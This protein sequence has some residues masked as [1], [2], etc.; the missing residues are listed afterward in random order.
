MLNKKGFTMVEMATTIVIAIPLVFSM[1]YV[2]INLYSKYK[3]YNN[4]TNYH[5][6]VNTLKNSLVHDLRVA[7]A[8]E[9]NK[10]EFNVGNH[11]YKFSDK[12]VVR[13]N[14]EISSYP[15]EFQMEDEVIR[16]KDK[17]TEL[18][19]PVGA[20]SLREVKLNE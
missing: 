3:D 5:M 6:E 17:N 18:E 11:S 1:I 9:K 20:K 10:K 15:F 7:N 8:E 4:L 19:F 2:P 16:L 13:D 14:L 12:G